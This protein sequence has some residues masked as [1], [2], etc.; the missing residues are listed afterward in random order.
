[1]HY[2]EGDR[3]FTARVVHFHTESPDGSQI[4]IARGTAVDIADPAVRRELDQ[5][6]WCLE[7]ARREKP[8]PY[9]ARARKEVQPANGIRRNASPT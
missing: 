5:C 1:M 7:T 9:L 4:G 2:Y 3:H 6:A 8:A